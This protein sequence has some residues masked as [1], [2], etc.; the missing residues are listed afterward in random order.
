MQG[1]RNANPQF[2]A[3]NRG[4]DI[5]G[6][7]AWLALSLL[8]GLSGMT[9]QPGTWYLGLAK[10]TWTPPG[11]LFGPVWTYLYITMAIAAW[12][13]WRTGPLKRT[14]YA[15]TAYIA[16]LA[17][18]ALWS[19]VFFGMHRI[20]WAFI[21]IAVLFVAIV[22]TAGLFRSHSRTAVYLL[23]P[24]LA[25]VGFASVLNFQIWHLN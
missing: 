4:R 11:W 25:W 5:G 17:L 15:L 6:L 12:L 20:G 13:V 9:F 2:P 24:Y 22:V 8:V 18:N 14:R 21:E 23:L 19:W 3:V 16:Q 1:G 10:P 7:V